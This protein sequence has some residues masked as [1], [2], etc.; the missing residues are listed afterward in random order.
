[1]LNGI[2]ELPYEFQLSGLYFFGSGE[3]FPTSAGSG[4]VRQQGTSFSGRVRANG[5]I[6]AANDFVGRPLHRVDLRVQK[7]FR[8]AAQT[9]LDAMIETFNVFNHAN[10]GTYTT[11]E[12]SPRFGQPSQTTSA[13]GQN[14]A[15]VPRMVQFGFR[16]AF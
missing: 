6:M 4:D 13:G 9:T 8:F 15:Y 5:T 10:Y 12:S 11:V 7:R 16:F 14:V 2:W 1:V 3:R